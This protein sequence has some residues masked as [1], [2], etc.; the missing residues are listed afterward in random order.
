[1]KKKFLIFALLAVFAVVCLGMAFA[2]DNNTFDVSGIKFHIPDGYHIE[3]NNSTGPSSTTITLMNND[4]K[5]CVISV[6][7]QV[8]GNRNRAQFGSQEIGRAHV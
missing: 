5:R 3:A 7:N 8:D 1:M 6:S 2:A 4:G